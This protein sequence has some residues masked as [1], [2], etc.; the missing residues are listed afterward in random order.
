MCAASS[1]RFEKLIELAKRKGFFWPSFEIYGGVS[2]FY[3]LGPLGA[4]LKKNI[5]DLWIKY[6]V[7]RHMD[8]AVIIETPVINPE[9]VFKASGH[10]ESF[11]DPITECLSC[12]RVFRADKL[13]EEKLGVKA[14][15][16]SPEELDRMIKDRGLRCPY[17]GG[18]L[19]RVK[20]FNLLFRTTIGPYTG[21]IG[22]LRPETAQGMFLAFKRIHTVMREKMPLGIAQ[23]GRVA[24]NEISPRQGMIRLRE[25]TIMEMEFFFDPSED[26]AP[27][28]EIGGKLRILSAEDRIRGEDKPASYDIR[29]AVEEGIVKSSWMAYWMGVSRDFIKELGLGEGDMFFEEKLPHERAHYAS[30]TFDQLVRV[31]RWGWIEVSGHAYRGDYDLSRHEQYSGKELRVFK[32]FKEPVE[33]EV[34]KVIVNKAVIGR[35]YKSKAGEVLKALRSVNPEEV[36]EL[37][38]KQSSE[39]FINIKGLKI[40]A[41]ALKVVK[42]RIKIHGEKIIPHVVEPSFG[43]ERL[44]Y[45]ALDNAYYEAED[46]RVVLRLPPKIAPIKAAVFPL[47]TNV[48]EIVEVARKIFKE[49]IRA[50]IPSIYD[51]SGNIGRRYARA[52]EIGVPY[53]ITVDHETLKDSTVTIRFRDTRKQVRIACSEV[54]DW[55]LSRIRI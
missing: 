17:C 38:K 32:R 41:N 21:T 43:A 37:L 47:V 39:D 19:S 7:I 49:L 13:I 45:V 52:D 29:E 50:G 18:E 51:E 42:E 44:V 26:S 24:R 2:G 54:I 40:P 4:L 16:L 36:E 34:K 27:L 1:D 25:F 48:S 28:D 30:Q 11:T 12:G 5:V 35:M 3:D 46:G 31:S 8:K 53:A 20:T 10:L 33:K 15:G 9:I 6:F 23:V 14:E 22:Y 55:I